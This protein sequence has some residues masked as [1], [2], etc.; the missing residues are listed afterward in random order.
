MNE[1]LLALALMASPPGSA[2]AT[3][4]VPSQQ[5]LLMANGALL[6]QNS[7]TSPATVDVLVAGSGWWRSVQL[8]PLTLPVDQTTTPW[9]LRAMAPTAPVPTSEE[10]TDETRVGLDRV[11]VPLRYTVAGG[12]KVWLRGRRLPPSKFTVGD[13][14]VLLAVDVPTA[15]G[16]EVVV[17][18]RRPLP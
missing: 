10:V 17:D 3:P 12:V 2:R 14:V 6:G 11:T 9:T 7:L 13:K 15:A 1:L 5:V 16:E 8:D 4:V 18:Y